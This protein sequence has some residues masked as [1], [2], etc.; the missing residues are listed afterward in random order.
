MIVLFLGTMFAGKS[1]KLIKIYREHHWVR[2][3][4]LVPDL[5][6][7]RQEGCIDGRSPQNR[8]VARTVK[9]EEELTVEL[10]ED[11][12][13]YIDEAQFFSLAF[14]DRL[15]W[16]QASHPELDIYIGALSLDSDAKPW[17]T[18]AALA[19][20]ADRV[21]RLHSNCA[22]CGGDAFFSACIEKREPFRESRFQPRCRDCYYR[23][24]VKGE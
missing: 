20:Y 10:P 9:T 11:G 15:V 8:L 7:S 4:C 24:N 6:G 1:R 13:L 3:T 21:E 17:P 14:A 19:C 22:I 23:H 18:S 16:W 2:R 12:D 5:P